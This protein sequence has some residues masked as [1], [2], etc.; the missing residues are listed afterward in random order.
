MRVIE[1]P[2]LRAVLRYGIPFVLIPTLVALSAVLFEGQ[3]YLI[4]SL[5]IA[6]LALLLF[7]AGVERRNIG[8]R[9]MVITAI[10]TLSAPPPLVSSTS[11]PS[12]SQYPSS[13]VA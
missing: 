4:I 10:M 7:A 5:G 12:S 2:R 11:R 6:V 3:R 8:S 13:I 1:T 9:R